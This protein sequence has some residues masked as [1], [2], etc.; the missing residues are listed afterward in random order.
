MDTVFH[1]IYVVGSIIIIIALSYGIFLNCRYRKREKFLMSSYYIY[2]QINDESRKKVFSK[3]LP[4]IVGKSK[5][6]TKKL[7]EE[8]SK[9]MELKSREFLFSSK[10]FFLLVLFLISNVLFLLKITG[11]YSLPKELE[12]AG[13]KLSIDIENFIARTML[14]QIFLILVDI[15]L[16]T[17]IN[18]HLDKFF[19]RVK[20][21][22]VYI[23]IS[24]L[25][26][27]GKNK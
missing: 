20:T 10:F 2:S 7:L 21:L 14:L 17:Y 24:N 13:I 4:Y 25:F 11:C 16:I 19:A 23:V 27:K 8:L 26:N 12:G 1:R 3:N 6:D 18:K 5:T 22:K 9:P 15:F